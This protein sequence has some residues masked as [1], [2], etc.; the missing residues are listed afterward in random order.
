MATT[1][2]VIGEQSKKLALFGSQC[3]LLITK[4]E[5]VNVPAFG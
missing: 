3:K 5:S 1:E 2:N 4:V